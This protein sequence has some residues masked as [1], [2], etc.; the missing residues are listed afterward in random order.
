[1]KSIIYSIFLISLVVLSSCGSGRK[2]LN[3][4]N[5]DQALAQSVKRLKQ[6]P[7]HKKAGDVLLSAYKYSLKS[8]LAVIDQAMVSGDS[9]RWD[10][11][12]A[13]YQVINA[14]ARLIQSCPACLEIIPDLYL[15][16]KEEAE[17]KA[18]AAAYHIREGKRKMLTRNI[19]DSRSAY[20]HFVRAKEYNSGN[21]DLDILIFNALEAGTIH[22]LIK[23]LPM[24]RNRFAINGEYFLT[25][26]L[27]NAR[28]LNYRFVR[29]YGEN[30]NI[31]API[32]EIITLSFDDFV[33][34]ETHTRE[35]IEE[36][37][38]DSVKIGETSEKDGKKPIYGTV[39]V[40]LHTFEKA[41][42]SNGLLD[43]RINNNANGQLIRQDKLPGTYVWKSQ[44]ATFNGDERALSREQLELTRRREM[45]PPP[46]QDLFILFTGPI[47]TQT[48]NLIRSQ[49]RL[50]Q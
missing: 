32:D 41:V 10:N 22:V 31:S 13:Q 44:W 26:I 42:V 29:F 17:C 38:K 25:T 27:E 20:D 16:L 37:K 19:Y 45:Q 2:Q 8:H 5:Y 18:L 12:V 28:R 49:Y 34:G 14:N 1:M 36:F 6:N 47:V 11:M 15:F 35:T 21:P 43:L 50:H 24:S 48:S 7:D 9:L 46:A 23:M 33:V 39:K 30:E 4:G 40:K 3:S